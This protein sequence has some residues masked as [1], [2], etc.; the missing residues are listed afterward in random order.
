R[1]NLPLYGQ[2]WDLSRE[3]NLS[4]I[5][6]SLL[7]QA[8]DAEPDVPEITFTHPDVTPNAMH[9]IDGFLEG[10]EPGHHIPGLKP[11]ARY[12]NIPWLEYYS[13]PLYDLVMHPLMGESWDSLA[14]QNLL[15]RAAEQGDTL[16]VA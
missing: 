1:I 4:V 15:D 2:S 11:S 12:L 8:L 13:S 3:A 10:R 7:G 6:Q 14:H 5:P 9:I 16:M